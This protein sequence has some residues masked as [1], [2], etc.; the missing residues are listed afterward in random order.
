M[1]FDITNYNIKA[2]PVVDSIPVDAT[3]SDSLTDEEQ[4]LVLAED[5]EYETDPL[6]TET[7]DDSWLP[8]WYIKTLTRLREEERVVRLQTQKYVRILKNRQRALAWKYQAR[9]EDRVRKDI[10]NQEGRRKTIHYGTGT[11]M[12]SNST[13]KIKVTDPEKFREWFEKQPADIREQIQ[14]CFDLK[15]ARTRPILEYVIGITGQGGTG[16]IPDG[17]VLTEGE[18]EALFSHRVE[19]PEDLELPELE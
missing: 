14:P 2:D 19:M 4:I 15:V 12:F 6:S 18:Q 16:D 7:G 11:A 13:P 9:V 3:G 10:E 5:L 1:T 8:A 17:C